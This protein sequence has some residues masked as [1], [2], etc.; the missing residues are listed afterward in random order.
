MTK[1]RHQYT[2]SLTG[3]DEIDFQTVKASEIK[4]IDIF[5]LGL[6]EALKQCPKVPKKAIEKAK[7]IVK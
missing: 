3:Q 7:A 2:I 1:T 4:Q 5:R 6:K